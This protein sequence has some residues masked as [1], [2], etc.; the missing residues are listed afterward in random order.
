MDYFPS[1]N[2][3][4]SNVS[5]MKIVPREGPMSALQKLCVCHASSL[6]GSENNFSQ[7]IRNGC[8]D[9]TYQGI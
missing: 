4:R 1:E 3:P 9:S 5:G 8:S 2:T 7:P 6:S